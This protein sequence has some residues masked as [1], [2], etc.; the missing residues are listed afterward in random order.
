MEK[1]LSDILPGECAEVRELFSRG[2]LRRRLRD[3]GL[4]EGTRVSCIGKSPGGD[5]SAYLV[6]GTVIA[7]RACDASEIAVTPLSEDTSWD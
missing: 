6:R 2:T 4:I 3:M 1:R 7:I 5:P